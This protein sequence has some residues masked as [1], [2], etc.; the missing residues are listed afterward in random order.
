MDTY[1]F[2]IVGG[3]FGGITVAEQ[4]LKK[5]YKVVLIS[6]SPHF[7][8]TPLLHE[9]A[10]GTLIA[11]D[12]AFEYEGFFRSPR[13]EFVLGEVVGI[14]PV[15]GHIKLIDREIGYKR[16]VIATGAR[17]NEHLVKGMEHAL[18]LKSVDDA[19]R[20]KRAL[21]IAAQR[22]KMQVTVVGGGPT[23]C[24]LVCEIE[25][26]LQTMKRVHPTWKLSVR[27]IHNQPKIGG[28]TSERMQRS[29]NQRFAFSSIEVVTE[30]FA[31][32][33]TSTSIL[34]SKGVF[35]SDVTVL[36]A[37][38]QPNT[39]AFV[40]VLSHDEKG[41]LRV[42]PTLQVQGHEAIFALGDV[43][44]LDNLVV[45]KLAQTA[46]QEGKIVAENLDRL[47][48]GRP[49]LSYH[50]QLLGYL[51]SLGF[52]KAVG[53]VAGILVRGV[54]GWYIWRTIYLFKTPGWRNKMRVAFSWTLGL[55]H[56]RD[57]TAL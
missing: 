2:V 44:S 45:P 35:D 14:D 28:A 47:M 21:L 55:F 20:L 29:I 32:E 39:E 15:A 4:L 5:G 56:G 40:S 48:H 25:E 23:G 22:G 18:T 7:T 42:K 26:F 57:L 37:G 33:I 53:E 50:P 31:Q 34:T 54:I 24:E 8:F 43:I 36:V 6:T 19:V 46:V 51:I 52:G 38:V 49:L 3:G 41:N 13:F 17:T 12:V 11:H 1:P 16:L 9:V 10:T 30:A 27:L